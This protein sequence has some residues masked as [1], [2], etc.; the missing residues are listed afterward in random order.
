MQL[1]QIEPVG[2]EVAEASLDKAG[3]VLAIV[4]F[5]A[6]GGGLFKSAE[7]GD[8]IPIELHQAVAEVL[9]YVFSLTN[10]RR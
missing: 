4:T 10:R 2:L 1:G 9:A 6:P 3:Q 8:E 7:V 5:R